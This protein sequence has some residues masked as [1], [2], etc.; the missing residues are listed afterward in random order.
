M[1]EG[2]WRLV[3]EIGRVRKAS[4]SRRVWLCEPGFRR[5]CGVEYTSEDGDRC[6]CSREA[7]ELYCRHLKVV[8]AS[9]LIE[10]QL[11]GQLLLRYSVPQTD[12]ATKEVASRQL[13]VICRTLDPWVKEELQRGTSEA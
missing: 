4:K 1:Q 8:V 2:S 11:K 6:N 10:R 3:G 5:R 7:Q 13:T 12:L 9:M